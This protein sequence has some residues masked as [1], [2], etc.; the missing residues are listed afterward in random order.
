MK[1]GYIAINNLKRKGEIGISRTCIEKIVRKAVEGV[2]GAKL[3][4]SKKSSKKWLFDWNEKMKIVIHKNEYV[5]VFLDVVVEAEA[6]VQEVCLKIQQEVTS[7]I[8]LMCETVP[9]KVSIRVVGIQ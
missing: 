1:S 3:N 9:L 6:N 4:S 8:S 7:A 2:P 5:E